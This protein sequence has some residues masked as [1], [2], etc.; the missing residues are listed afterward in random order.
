[1]SDQAAFGAHHSLNPQTRP[2]D[3]VIS[4]SDEANPLYQ[5]SAWTPQLTAAGQAVHLSGRR[6]PLWSP[7]V[8]SPG[9][10][11]ERPPQMALA[12]T[13][14]DVWPAVASAAQ[15]LQETNAAAFCDVLQQQMTG[16]AGAAEALTG[17][18]LACRTHAQDLRRQA[19]QQH[20]TLRA[21][22][23]QRHAAELDAEAATWSLLQHLQGNPDLLYP[24]GGELYELADANARASVGQRAA[25]VVAGN[26]R[27]NR[28]ARLVAWLEDVAAFQLDQE[29]SEAERCGAINSF[30]AADGVWADTRQQQKQGQSRLHL[31]SSDK[32]ITSLDPDAPVREGKDLAEED[33]KQEGRLTAHLF[34]LLRCG[35]L[36]TASQLARQVSQ[37]WR[38][39]SMAGGGL[40]GPLPLGQA[41]WDAAASDVDEAVAGED[42]NGCGA[43][44][45]LWKWACYQAAEKSAAAYQEHGGCRGGMMEAALYAALAGHLQCLLPLAASWEDLCWALSRCWLDCEVDRLLSSQ[46]APAQVTLE[47]LKGDLGECAAEVDMGV[48]SEGLSLLQGTWPLPRMMYQLPRTQAEVFDEAARRLAGQ[49]A[50]ASSAPTRHQRFQIQLALA[51]EAEDPETHTELL[52]ILLQTIYKQVL[53]QGMAEEAAEDMELLRFGAHLALAL[54]DL[55]DSAWNC[56]KPVA[57]ARLQAEEALL[58]H[59][60]MHLVLSGQHDMVPLYACHVQPATR[61]DSYMALMD[62]LSDHPIEAHIH[63]FHRSDVIFEEWLA[64]EPE[65]Q[66]EADTM[67]RLATQYAGKARLATAHGPGYRARAMQWMCCSHDAPALWAALDQATCLFRE[68]CLAGDGGTVAADFLIWLLDER[69]MVEA[70]A[71]AV[72]TSDDFQLRHLAHS[73]ET[74]IRYFGILREYRSWCGAWEALTAGSTSGADELGDMYSRAVRLAGLLLEFVQTGRFD[75]LAAV[76]PSSQGLSNQ[77]QLEVTSTEGPADARDLQSGRAFQRM[78]RSDA[79]SLAAALEAG[80]TAALAGAD[81]LRDTLDFQVEATSSAAGEREPASLVRIS[82]SWTNIEAAAAAARLLSLALKTALPP[83][84]GPSQPAAGPLQVQNMHGCLEGQM[85]LCQALC[86]PSL[87]LHCAHL[88]QVLLQLGDDQHEESNQVYRTNS[89][90]EN[91]HLAA[92]LRSIVLATTTGCWREAAKEGCKERRLQTKL[93]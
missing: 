79:D 17:F 14:P 43:S 35:R 32:L 39:T 3:L 52:T 80:M 50:A 77:M 19:A 11:S 27:L 36:H 4:S 45:A 91:C 63:V 12:V 92:N 42:E 20:R 10:A 72:D 58:K 88:H 2:P 38:A 26:R 81:H 15:R 6:N 64:H 82:M 55:A 84:S 18:S 66:L 23:W 65:A 86:Y 33:A 60:L 29:D 69:E 7:D 1:M 75:A 24:A 62:L 70:A 90:A 87:L 41:A 5:D 67:Q 37:P 44:R 56:T 54:R 78:A 16:Q 47:D 53:A 59:Y 48:L 34:R 89:A 51:T 73:V 57:D 21:V 61:E 31:S 76:S 25:A 74:W 83:P 28:V 68:F 46:P 40:Y 13:G 93:L 85:L 71:S 30:V 49:S 22:Q 8:A 9:V